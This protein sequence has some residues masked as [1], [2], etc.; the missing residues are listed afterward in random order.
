MILKTKNTKFSKSVISSH[1]F[2]H[3]NY[4]LMWTCPEG[5]GHR[6][7]GKSSSGSGRKRKGGK[8]RV[9]SGRRW[10]STFP[11]Q[12]RQFRFESYDNFFFFNG[13]KVFFFCRPTLNHCDK[14][15]EAKNSPTV[16]QLRAPCFLHKIPYLLVTFG[17]F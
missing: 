16:Q 2:H 8:C 6:P 14:N 5:S 10:G 3:N 1:I 4:I 17:Y 11:R 15:D 7:V 9:P 13:L 12:L